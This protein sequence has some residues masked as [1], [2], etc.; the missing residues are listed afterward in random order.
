MDKLEDFGCSTM[1]DL[2]LK[3]KTLHKQYQNYLM[4]DRKEQ[5]ETVQKQINELTTLQVELI[6]DFQKISFDSVMERLEDIGCLDLEDLES[7]LKVL[8]K[9]YQTYLKKGRNDKAVATQTQINE[10]EQLREDFMK[11][12]QN[13]ASIEEK[14][15]R[16]SC[17]NLNLFVYCISI[18]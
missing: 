15:V 16:N 14:Q 17:L 1:E 13:N 18:Y 5:A 9:E 11:L 8:E 10:L 6:K 7:K 3:L 12:S 4:K 2:E